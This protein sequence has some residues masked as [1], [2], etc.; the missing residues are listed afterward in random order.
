MT[1]ENIQKYAYVVNTVILLMVFGLMAFFWILDVPFL[2][3]FSIP[4]ACVYII[5]YI[6]ISKNK[7]AIYVWMVYMPAKCT[8]SDGT[9]LESDK[10]FFEKIR[11]KVENT[12]FIY[13]GNPIKVTITIGVEKR[14]NHTS[15][16]KWINR[17]D[18]N[19][20]IGKNNGRNKVVV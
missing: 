13:E 8:V 2:V 16:D 6:L 5:G 20:Y 19:L 18:E 11:E 17:A 1:Q 4:T 3:I 14:G 15:I 10:D 7:L 12:D 9:V